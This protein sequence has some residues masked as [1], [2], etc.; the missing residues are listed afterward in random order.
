M[1]ELKYN[2]ANIRALLSKGFTDQQLRDL[3]F[4]LAA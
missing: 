1:A 3:C 4:D 2:F